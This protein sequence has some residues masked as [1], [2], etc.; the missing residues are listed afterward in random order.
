[1]IGWLRHWWHLPVIFLSALALRSY[2][3]N[4]PLLDAHSWRQA[5]TAAIARNFVASRF[6]FA[7]PQVDWGGTTT[8]DVESE[9]PL[10]TG[11]LALLFGTFGVQ[12]WL[13]RLLTALCSAAAPLALY[14]LIGAQRPA[15]ALNQRAALYA[16]LALCLLPFAVYFG[17]TVMP[18]SLMLLLAILAIWTFQRWLVRP[19]H[20]RFAL[21][22]VCGTL[23]PL[24]KTPNLLIVAVPLA[25]LTLTGRPWRRWPQL[26]LYGVGFAL[27][28]LL[29]TR[30]AHALPLDPRLSF[31]IGEK[32]FDLE[33]LR[34]PQFYLLV[35]SWALNDLLTLAG[36]P[37]FLLGLVWVLLAGFRGQA[38]T[39]SGRPAAEY[40][41]TALLACFWLLGVL[42]FVAIGAAG[43]VGQDYY[44]LPLVGP[45]AWLI[46][47]GIAG[48][49]TWAEHHVTPQRA[50]L[51]P[52]VALLAIGGLS[53]ARVVPLYQ[54]TEFYRT[55]GQR[56]DLALP[57]S[58]RVGV[59]APAVS[60]I[61]FYG[62]RKGWRLD[63]GVL[64]PGGLASLGPDLGVRY[65]LIADPWLTERRELL[66]HELAA[67]RRVPVGPY[68]L[69]LDLQQP[70]Y[71]QP[72]ALVWETGHVVQEPFL[73]AWQRSGGRATLGLPISDSLDDAAGRRQYFER[74]VLVEHGSDVGFAPAGRELLAVARKAPQPAPVEGAFDLAWRSD[75]GM[76]TLG[77]SISAV[78]S[79][80]GQQVQYFENGLLE[81]QPDGH[82]TRGAVGR[83]LLD[84]RGLTEE[85]QIEVKSEK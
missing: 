7:H 62:A 80:R 50:A 64:V 49:Q 48:V 11:V 60:E 75:G 65:V 61:L 79:E 81:Q 72:F 57:P 55:L 42:A 31:G 32:L 56:V 69:L 19:T 58:A 2:A 82:V 63:P 84:A 40:N 43:V 53:A 16:A 1:M 36:V 6:H 30:H 77:A 13:G 34:D 38:S 20:A 54:T 23:A 44:L 41:H 51:V 76:A 27:P 28:V 52:V 29:W 33:L 71:T 73:N 4:A 22:L 74:A 37:L 10:Y 25:Y 21:A 85:R 9:F 70:G 68:A 24:A 3:L 18:D 46:G 39:V 35:G 17:R 59:I 14:G 12:A 8:G 45:A 5:D 83:W 66:T 47:A 15:S 78:L 26:L 67:Y